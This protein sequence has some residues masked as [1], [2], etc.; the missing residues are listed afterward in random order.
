M[1]D[2]EPAESR[3]VEV[4]ELNLTG[5]SDVSYV[6]HMYGV[7]LHSA[8]QLQPHLER[9]REYFRGCPMASQEDV[10]FSV[11]PPFD[12]QPRS[13]YYATLPP[14]I[15]RWVQARPE[16]KWIERE[17][18]VPDHTVDIVH[19]EKRRGTEWVVL[20]REQSLQ[21]LVGC[22]HVTHVAP[23]SKDKKKK[24]RFGAAQQ[25]T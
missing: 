17:T 3:I 11:D 1:S 14:I 10:E 18:A 23:E 2:T 12:S 6:P 16:V 20:M 8:D 21:Y 24:T 13:H 25:H 9:L 19:E 5:M 15:L 22:K 4:T 7:E